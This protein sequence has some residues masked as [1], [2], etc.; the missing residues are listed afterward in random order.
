[1]FLI[2]IVYVQAITITTSKSTPKINSEDF[3]ENEKRYIDPSENIYRLA[4]YS[5]F[6][7]TL[8]QY[9]YSGIYLL[10][11]AYLLAIVEVFFFFGFFFI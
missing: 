1:M 9:S 10:F 11:V 2:V 4:R 7:S 3:F 8:I 6:E 5:S